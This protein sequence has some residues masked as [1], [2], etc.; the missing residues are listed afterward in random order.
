MKLFILRASSTNKCPNPASGVKAAS[1][2][3]PSTAASDTYA[4]LLLRWD[5]SVAD[6]PLWEH[7]ADKFQMRWEMEMR[8]S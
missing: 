1:P 5:C 6:E 7:C 3:G 4:A 2:S 8:P